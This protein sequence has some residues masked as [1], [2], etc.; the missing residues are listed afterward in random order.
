MAIS[1]SNFTFIHLFLKLINTATPRHQS[2]NTSDLVTSDVIELKNSDIIITTINAWIILKML[3]NIS[4][5]SFLVDRFLVHNILDVLLFILSIILA[6]SIL[7]TISAYILIP[8]LAGLSSI[9][10]GL[11]LSMLA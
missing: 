11:G 6:R 10:F 7:I 4:S 2:A 3:Y 9:E 8:V 1:T 5:I